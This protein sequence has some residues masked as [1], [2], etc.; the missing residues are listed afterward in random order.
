MENDKDRIKYINIARG[1]T[2]FFV[3]FAHTIVPDIRK[4]S[5]IALAAFLWM[6]AFTIHL[7]MVISGYL[8]QR[9]YDKY[10]SKGFIRFIRAKLPSSPRT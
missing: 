3:V 8:Y 4:D 1:F 10:R 6:S 9:S 5:P 7:F 2:C